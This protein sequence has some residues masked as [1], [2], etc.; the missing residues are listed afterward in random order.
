MRGLGKFTR[1]PVYGLLLLE[2]DESVASSLAASNAV[3]KACRRPHTESLRARGRRAAGLS[4][5]DE[6]RELI[7]QRPLQERGIAAITGMTLTDAPI[8]GLLPVA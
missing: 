4:I 3:S 7:I 2:S 8:L 6:G 5:A 1:E